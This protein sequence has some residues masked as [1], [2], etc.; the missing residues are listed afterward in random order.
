MDPDDIVALIALIIYIIYP[1][2]KKRREKTRE[3]KPKKQKKKRQKKPARKPLE[4]MRR[5]PAPIAPPVRTEHELITQTRDRATALRDR[6]AALLQQAGEDPRNERFV[7]AIQSDVLEPVATFLSRLDSS[8]SLSTLMQDSQVLSDLGKLLEIF[9]A[10]ARQRLGR[11]IDYLSDADQIADACYGPLISFSEAHGVP[12][13]TKTPIAVRSD[14]DLSIVFNLAETSV[15][16]LRVPAAL[17]NSLWLWPGVAHEVAQDF[18]YSVDDLELSLHRRLGLPMQAHIPSH[19]SDINSLFVRQMFGPW[20]P[21]IFSDV[22]ATWTL[23]P[24]YVEAMQ[25]AYARRDDPAQAAAVHHDG[26][27][28][29]VQPP[30]HLRLYIAARVLHHL[31]LHKEADEQWARWKR[32][33]QDQEVIYVPIQDQWGAVEEE[34]FIEPADDLVDALLEQS[35][36]EL[37]GATLIAIP[38]LPYLHAEHSRVLA[39]QARLAN[40]EQVHAASRLVIAAAI[41]AA[42][43]NPAQHDV[44]LQAARGSITGVTIKEAAR[45]VR[46]VRASSGDL[47]G[48]FRHSLRN[49]AAIREA[50]IVGAV[51]AP[52]QSR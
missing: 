35:W 5:P 46:G 28:I 10:M 40:G 48:A 18:F 44:I 34:V 27:L 17:S 33:H 4:A 30:A 2:F 26:V 15:A 1:F 39:L 23:G 42:A 8:M 36:P 24:A 14:W 13:R 38:G 21:K 7:N 37:S 47:A 29:D 6:A 50:I 52:R 31:G 9:E 49:P 32:E 41:L 43:A 20:L 25:R 11:D 45:P 19:P 16:P 51:F 12:L 22:L 3:Q